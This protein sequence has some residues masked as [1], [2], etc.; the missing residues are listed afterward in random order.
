MCR[1]NMGLLERWTK[2]RVHVS[3]LL[4]VVV[5]GAQVLHDA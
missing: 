4:S 5:V 3:L 2:K 1:Y